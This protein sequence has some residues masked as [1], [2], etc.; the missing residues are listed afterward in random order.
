MSRGLTWT[1]LFGGVVLVAL[2]SY[3]LTLQ[4]GLGDYDSG[5]PSTESSEANADLADL[6]PAERLCSAQTTVDSIRQRIFSRAR[7]A[8]MEEEA[9]ALSRLETGTVAR[10]EGVRLV[11]FDENRE[12]ARCEGRLVLELPR[13]TEPAFNYSRRLV[14]NIDY[15]AQPGPSGGG[16]IARMSGADLLIDQLASADL[17]TQRRSREDIFADEILGDDKE[18]SDAR[19]FDER[20]GR[21]DPRPAPSPP[22]DPAGSAEPPEDLLPPEMQQ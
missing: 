18:E 17:L 12:Q 8:Q 14:A 5:E 6:T 11:E 19:P 2:I 7:A 13:G 16:M 20:P 1:L 15:V 22:P 9:A 3:V 21:V 10:M 4:M